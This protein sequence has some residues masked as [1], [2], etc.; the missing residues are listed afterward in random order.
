MVV[1]IFAALAAGCGGTTTSSVVSGEVRQK[2]VPRSG[3]TSQSCDATHTVACSVGTC[4][5]AGESCTLAVRPLDGT[6]FCAACPADFPA[7]CSQTTCCKS[8]SACIVNGVLSTIGTCG[9][10]TGQAACGDVC[11]PKGAS[12]VS[13]VCRACP[14]SAPTLC[15][16]ECRS[17]ACDPG[18]TG[19]S[20]STGCGNGWLSSCDNLCYPTSAACGAAGPPKG[21]YSG[22][23]RQCP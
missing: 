9:C 4:C 1:I 13:G 8:A 14:D 17:G 3:K 20:P 5:G 23:C 6:S 15:G 22:S 18:P 11:C 7:S 2:T 19:C 10:P 16:T 12:C 21:C